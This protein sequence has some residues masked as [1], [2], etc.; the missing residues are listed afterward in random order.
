MMECAAAGR[1]PLG[2]PV[3]SFEENAP[4]GGGILLPLDEA[5]FVQEA[6]VQLNF[7]RENKMAFIGKCKEIKEYALEYYDWRVKIAP[8]IKLFCE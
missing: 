8:W 7:Y 1:L 4:Q 5:A 6:Q 2:T 3:G